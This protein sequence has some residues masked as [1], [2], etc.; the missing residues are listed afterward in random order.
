MDAG[1]ICNLV[2]I[3]RSIFCNFDTQFL[4]GGGI[5]FSPAAQGAVAVAGLLPAGVT[6]IALFPADSIPQQLSATSVIFR[7]A[8]APAGR[9][10]KRGAY[11]FLGHPNKQRYTGKVTSEFTGWQFSHLNL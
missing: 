1:I 8:I 2:F 4:V 6:P 9:H 10:K 5:A 7:E 11:S 3:V